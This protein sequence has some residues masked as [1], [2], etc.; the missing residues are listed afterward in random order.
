[1]MR[2]T[3]RAGRAVLCR[4]GFGALGLFLCAGG[5]RRGTVVCLERRG[6]RTLLP[7]MG[8]RRSYRPAMGR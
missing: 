3:E 7:A 2:A 5:K 6:L 4:T 8:S 1:M